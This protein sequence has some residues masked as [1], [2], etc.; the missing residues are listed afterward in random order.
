MKKNWHGIM[1]LLEVQHLSETGEILWSQKNILNLLHNTG[2]QFILNAVFVG[3]VDNTFIPSAYYVGL[4]NRGSIVTTDTM[5]TVNGGGEPTGNGYVRQAISSSG[6]FVVSAQNNNYKAVSPL[7][8]FSATGGSWGPVSNI[9][10]TTTANFSG[11]LIA[12]AQLATPITVT[13]G[14][15]ITIRAGMT[16]RDESEDE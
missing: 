13:S 4:D 1:K 10:L 15:S 3:G 9:F 14:Q 7:L 5:S 11:I 2:E 12:S 16:L 6:Q 8:S